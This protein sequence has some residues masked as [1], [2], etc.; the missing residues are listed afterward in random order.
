MI[1]EYKVLFNEINSMASSF[2]HTLKIN[3]IN[4]PCGNIADISLDTLG[5]FVKQQEIICQNSHG[6]IH[7]SYIMQ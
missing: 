4:I 6:T 1:G 3:G 7:F 2:L 5:F